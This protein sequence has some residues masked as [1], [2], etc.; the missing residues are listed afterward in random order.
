MLHPVNKLFSVILLLLFFCWPVCAQ[1]PI[2]VQHYQYEI[3]LSDLSDVIVGKATIKIK[4]LAPAS[5]VLLD[6]VGMKE[7]K[8]MKVFQVKEDGK[9]V[10][11]VHRQ[12]RLEIRPDASAM[13]NQLR[14]YE[15]D[16]MGVPEDGLIISSNKYGER[17]FFADNWPNRARNWIPCV[18]DPADKASVEFIV[19][20]PE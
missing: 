20:A 16:Y 2:D 13:A 14:T 7:E 18:D 11:F 17:T 9:S 10:K 1:R 12:D 4:F 3:S 6:L 19:K 15:I 8:G 5:T